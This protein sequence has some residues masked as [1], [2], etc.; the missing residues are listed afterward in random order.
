MTKTNVDEILK[1]KVMSPPFRCPC[2]FERAATSPLGAMTPHEPISSDTREQCPKCGRY[3]TREESR[4][5]TGTCSCEKCRQLCN[6]RPGLFAPTEVEPAAAEFGLTLEEFFERHL[7]IN[8]WTDDP[9][10]GD[11]DGW[12]HVCPGW[13]P[14]V[15]MEPF[16]PPRPRP[17]SGPS[18][19]G[20]RCTND[21]G[22]TKG[23]C[24]LLGPDGCRLSFDRR[25]EECRRAYG[26]NPDPASRGLALHGDV[27]KKWKTP[28]GLALL[29]R[30]AKY[31]V[32]ED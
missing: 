31:N 18:T 23:P 14:N 16:L 24:S 11:L 8:W 17:Y 7:T 27:A 29:A 6:G 25:P 3:L 10:A 15:I 20:R 9:D 32:Q 5:K 1:V 13:N 21:E 12:D 30:L 4:A 26:C 19:V 22:R 28:E 2:G